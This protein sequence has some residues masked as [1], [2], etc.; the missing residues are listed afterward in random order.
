[1]A[2]YYVG[3]SSI[4]GRGVY[5]SRRF[6]TGER[7]LMLDDSRVITP[8]HP[9]R[10][11]LGEC[12]DHVDHL[13]NGT[14]VYMQEP[15]RYLNHCCDPNAFCRHVDNARYLVARR[16]IARDEEIVVD[17]C[18]NSAESDY[19]WPCGCGAARCRKVGR[20]D[21]FSLPLKFQ[22]EYL[23]LLDHWFLQEHRE[24]LRPL[25]E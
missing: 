17:Y 14:L 8:E 2:D 9:L 11:E 7:I 16:V 23:P 3:T 15:E 5:A 4:A 21:F 20:L 13:A 18:V 24:R 1:M 25:L 6:E 10:P 22:L 12:D 19:S